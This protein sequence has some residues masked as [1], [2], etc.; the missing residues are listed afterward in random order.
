MFYTA[1][2]TLRTREIRTVINLETQPIS[3][4]LKAEGKNLNDKQTK[5]ELSDHKYNFI[6]KIFIQQSPGLKII[7][8]L[9][10]TDLIINSKEFIAPQK[11]SEVPECEYK[12]YFKSLKSAE[13]DKIK[14]NSF[15]VQGVS[16]LRHR[17]IISN[18]RTHG[19]L[20][21]FF[22]YS[23]R[24]WDINVSNIL[25]DDSIIIKTNSRNN[26][27]SLSFPHEWKKLHGALVRQSDANEISSISE[28]TNI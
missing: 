3:E 17:F 6:S 12:K 15:K 22:T 7:I 9:N 4:L 26:Q 2:D 23:R 19:D 5:K 14:V 27:F 10:T 11:S 28:C 18:R 13:L 24:N 16:F 8:D 20:K 25:L 21:E 1:L